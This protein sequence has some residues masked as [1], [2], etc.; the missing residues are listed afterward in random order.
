MSGLNYFTEQDPNSVKKMSFY[1]MSDAPPDW[2][3]D[4]PSQPDYIANKENAE[5]FRPVYVDEQEVLDKSR[6]SGNLHLVSG[7]N[8]AIEVDNATKKIIISSAG[9]GGS[10]E[11]CLSKIVSAENGGIEVSEKKEGTQKIGLNKDAIFVFDCNW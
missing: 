1:R 2:E 5:S 6:E 10:N 11:N 3:Q 4:D 7:E 8:I 9:G